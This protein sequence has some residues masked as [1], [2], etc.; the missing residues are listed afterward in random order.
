MKISFG[1]MLDLVDLGLLVITVGG[2]LVVLALLLAR[3]ARHRRRTSVLD[4]TSR[5]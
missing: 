2:S 3:P 1:S 4:P 5:R